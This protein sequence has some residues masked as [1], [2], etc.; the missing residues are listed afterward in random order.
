MSKAEPD[1]QAGAAGDVHQRA[2]HR[3]GLHTKQ[4]LERKMQADAE[5]QQHDAQ[6]GKFARDLAI[7]D[8]AGREGTNNDARDQIAHQWR[9]PQPVGDRAEDKGQHKT[10]DD[11]RDQRGVVRHICSS[12]VET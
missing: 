11:R 6:F 5:H 12:G 8:K 3:D 9:H 1:A 4:V 7:G 2:R 10:R